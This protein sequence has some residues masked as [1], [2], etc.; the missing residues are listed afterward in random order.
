MF[1]YL[2]YIRLLLSLIIKKVRNI[3]KNNPFRNKRL[4]CPPLVSFLPNFIYTHPVFSIAEGSLPAAC[5][6]IFEEVTATSVVLVLIELSTA[7]SN[8]IVGFKLWYSKTTEPTH[9]KDPVKTF[10]RSQRRILISNLQPCTE[11]VFRVVSYTDIGDLGHSEAKCF[12]GS[13]EIIHKNPNSVVV[14]HNEGTSSAKDV[15]SDSGFR[16]R[17]LG[18]II[19]LAWAQE[20]GCLDGISG[21]KYRFQDVIHNNPNSVM[22]LFLS[23]NIYVTRYILGW[24][25][26]YLNTLVAS[27]YIIQLK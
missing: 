20:R 13:V 26:K 21:I 16:V 19:R 23:S 12:T 11:Y 22:F 25:I 18:K 14:P 15:E 5:K 3:T 1:S 8:D 17:E 2:V 27:T 24:P 6:F 4:K 9:T 10:S 7:L